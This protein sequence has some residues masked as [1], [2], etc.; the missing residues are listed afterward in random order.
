MT[1]IY[2]TRHGQ[3]DWNVQKRMQ[4]QN[5]SP[6]TALGIQQAKALG[7][8]L[9]GIELSTIYSSSSLRAIQTAELIKGKRI[10]EIIPEEDLRE[11]NLGS[12]EGMFYSEIENLYPGKFDD[13]WNHPE[14]YVPLD[15]ETYEALKKRIS[16]KMEEIAKRHQGETILVV[17]HGIVIKTLYTYFRNQSIRDIIHSPHPK[18]TCLCMAEKENGVWNIMKWNETAHYELI[19]FPQGY[20]GYQ[21][22]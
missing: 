10:L 22:V 13:F 15:G 16:G 20:E 5:N 8:Y 6:L 18:S 2:L 3:T 19:D 14:Q 9:S 11:I 21:E 12:W 7:D 1:R 17:A 4:G